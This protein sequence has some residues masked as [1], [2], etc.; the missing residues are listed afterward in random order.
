MVLS[1]LS[2]SSKALFQKSRAHFLADV[3]FGSPKMDEKGLA[4]TLKALPR[5]AQGAEMA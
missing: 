2:K 4:G 1:L 5:F 3:H